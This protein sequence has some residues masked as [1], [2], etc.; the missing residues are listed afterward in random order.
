[1]KRITL[2]ILLFYAGPLWAQCPY[3]EIS[4][5]TQAQ[6]DAF[7]ATY[8]N[9]QDLNGALMIQGSDIV[10]LDSLSEILSIKG[11]LDIKG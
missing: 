2:L 5:T 6:V 1:M 3:G 7:K 10:S 8:P 4:L 9:C 11:S